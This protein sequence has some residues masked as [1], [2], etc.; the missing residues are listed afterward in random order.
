MYATDYL[1]LLKIVLPLA[2]F[3][4]PTVTVLFW[5]DP[6]CPP[7]LYIV[8]VTTPLPG[9]VKAA[10]QGLSLPFYFP[11]PSDPFIVKLLQILLLKSGTFSFWHVEIQEKSV[12]VG[13]A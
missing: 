1:Q 7:Y 12:F 10:P 4:K 6:L 13:T 3:T 9:F 5:S 11:I 8:P 2:L